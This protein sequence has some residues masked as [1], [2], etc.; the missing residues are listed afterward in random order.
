MSG[1]VWPL[2]WAFLGPSWCHL[3][4][5]ITSGDHK[6]IASPKLN[7]YNVHGRKSHCKTCFLEL[8]KAVVHLL[9]REQ[10]PV[11]KE[12]TSIRKQKNRLRNIQVWTGRDLPHHNNCN[13][14]GEDL[15]MVMKH[16]NLSS[17]VFLV[18]L[19]WGHSRTLEHWKC[20]YNNTKNRLVFW[21]F[22]V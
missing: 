21:S 12:H 15:R 22:S 18:L 13:S 17:C 10:K 19:I 7:T 20:E 3:A 5:P 6:T 14:L 2:P 11:W 8:R 1:Q 4:P 9:G 16:R